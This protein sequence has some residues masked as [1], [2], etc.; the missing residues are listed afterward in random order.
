MQNLNTSAILSSLSIFFLILFSNQAF[1][2][3]FV[4]SVGYFHS[5]DK[6]SDYQ[7]VLLKGSELINDYS[8]SYDSVRERVGET[9]EKVKEKTEETK[10]KAEKVKEKKNETKSEAKEKVEK[11]KSKA[12]EKTKQVEEKAEDTKEKVKEKA[13][14]VEQEDTEQFMESFEEL[15]EQDLKPLV[16]AISSDFDE[17]TGKNLLSP[18]GF[19][20]DKHESPKITVVGIDDS[21]ITDLQLHYK[22]DDGN[23]I[24]VL[25]ANKLSKPMLNQN[26]IDTFSEENVQGISGK[27]PKQPAGSV[28]K[29]RGFVGDLDRNENYSPFGMYYVTDSD[30]PRVLIVDPHVRLWLLQE[31]VQQGIENSIS[32]LDDYD[33]LKGI[34]NNLESHPYL[35]SID[36]YQKDIENFRQW[37]KITD[38]YNISVIEP[39]QIQE[40]LPEFKPDTIILSS[41]SLGIEEEPRI[42]D[43]DFND[44]EFETL[45]QYL[46]NNNAGL[47][48]TH[49][50][51]SDSVL[52][53][54]EEKPYK[55]GSRD[56]IGDSVK[57]IETA[58]YDEKTVSTLMGIPQLAIYEIAKDKLAQSICPANLP[59]GE[60]VGSIPLHLPRIPFDG[61]LVRTQDAD[62]AGIILPNQFLIKS[63]NHKTAFTQIGWQLAV[64]WMLTSDWREGNYD[65]PKI[66]I[67]DFISNKQTEDVKLA[68]KEF[69]VSYFLTEIESQIDKEKINVKFSRDNPNVK[70]PLNIPKVLSKFKEHKPLNLVAKS[71]DSRAGIL[72]FN[73]Y[74]TE[75]GYRSVYISFEPETAI[76]P[77]TTPEVILKNSIEWTKD[78][79]HENPKEILDQK[80]NIPDWVKTNAKWWA[81]GKIK[82][83]DFVKG[84][85]H[86]VKSDIISIPATQQGASDSTEPVP[87]WIKRNAKWWAEGQIDDSD[88]IQGIQFM[89]KEGIIQISE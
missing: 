16:F 71:T 23:W 13:P 8:I 26:I 35:N 45:K 59:L 74:W 75:D 77:D 43:W 58:I 76:N 39:S 28:V 31:N 29:F 72:T 80:D 1:A 79:Q 50:S 21:Q 68:T 44:A 67:P 12:E 46:K 78:W 60:I 19:T 3:D 65:E 30:K 54:C 73:K 55:I 37:Q 4:D 57:D 41:L 81:E 88:F 87:Q 34:R 56:T 61:E 33:Q 51:L 42:F 84:I 7:S 47:V 53:T 2:V 62:T 22:V 49:S 9:K 86:M 27:I 82:E 89:V 5:R 63:P 48:V 66:T 52:W 6:G 85:E 25:S 20:V 83:G 15:Q 64:P 10:E 17:T 11:T 32:N 69:D 14:Q 18:S 40:Y 24:P 70:I 38:D 36:V